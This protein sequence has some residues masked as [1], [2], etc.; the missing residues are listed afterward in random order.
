MATSKALTLPLNAEPETAGE[1]GAIPALPRTLCGQSPAIRVVAGM[2]VDAGRRRGAVLVTGEP[3]TGREDVARAIHERGER[4]DAPFIKI[5]CAVSLPELERELFGITERRQRAS[6]R[7]NERISCTSLVYQS[8][9]GTLFLANVVDA[10]ARVQAK[11][12]RL[13]R[14]REALLAEEGAVSELDVRAIAA[15]DPGVEASVL[16][17]RLHRDLHSRLSRTRIDLPP[18]RRRR[19]DIPILAQHFLSE[20]CAAQGIGPKHL[21]R[22]ALVLLTA[23]PWNGNA[24]ELRALLEVL[25][26]AVDGPVIELDELLAHVRLDT[27]VAPVEPDRTLRDAR[28]RFERDYITAALL[29]H[30]G[31]VG[32]AASALG[33]QRTNLY[34]KV[35]QLNVARS[36]LGGGKS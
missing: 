10:P 3:G 14:D 25:A 19:E 9:G 6:D 20:I 24:K 21:S 26:R 13:L 35:R 1:Q 32:K 11:L 7:D 23:L 8:H 29:A 4:A 33:I 16:N 36:L 30:Q 22:F 17:G 34:R 27:G 28:N 18:L 5:D 31:K 2:I 15:M 12:A